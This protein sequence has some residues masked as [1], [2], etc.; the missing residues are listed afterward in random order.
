[1]GIDVASD[2][3]RGLGVA[4]ATEEAGPTIAASNALY[5]VAV[6]PAAAELGDKRL[7]IVP[8]G[9]LNYVPFQ[10]LVTS[11][12]ASDFSTAPY[13]VKTNEIVSAPSASVISAVRQ[14][15]NKPGGKAMLIVADPVFN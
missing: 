14:S 8:D 9:A 6:E 15:A 5:K 2:Q 3:Q 7:L 12:S 13:L 1:V 4:T 11:P 10:A